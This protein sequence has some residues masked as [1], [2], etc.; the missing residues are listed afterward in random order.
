MS[1][2]NLGVFSDNQ[3]LVA[4]AASTNT[5]DMATTRQQIGAGVPIYICI[6]VGAAFTVATSYAFDLQ[7]DSTAAFGSAAT[8]PLRAA[9]AIASL[10]AGAWVYRAPFPYEATERH[11]R[12]YYTEA[13]STE[14]TGTVDAWLSLKPPTDYGAN[15]QVWVSPVGNP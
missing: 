14:S 1:F 11:V 3:S 6:R 9:I 2:S 10:T 13:G 12:L 15:A 7:T 5:I 4:S 8:F